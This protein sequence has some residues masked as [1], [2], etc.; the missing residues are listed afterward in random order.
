MKRSL[1]IDPTIV[2][3]IPEFIRAYYNV[4]D[5]HTGL[6]S[7]FL[8]RK[9]FSVSDL[10]TSVTMCTP[11][12]SVIFNK[13]R[14]TPPEESIANG[15][16]I[17]EIEQRFK[18][19]SSVD[20]L[21]VALV[22]PGFVLKSLVADK[23][24]KTLNSH[25]YALLNSRPFIQMIPSDASA[26]SRITLCGTFTSAQKAATL[27]RKNWN[28][29]LC[30]DF[31]DTYGSQNVFLRDHPNYIQPA[32]NF[33]PQSIFV[34]RTDSSSNPVSERIVNMMSFGSTSYNSGASADEMDAATD[35]YDSTRNYYV[36]EQGREPSP[37]V[38]EDFAAFHSANYSKSRDLSDAPFMF[39]HLLPGGC[40]G[41]NEPNRPIKMSHHRW[42]C[43]ML[44]VHHRG[45]QMDR[46]FPAWGQT[47]ES[48]QNSY[49][50]HFLTMRLQPYIL[51]NSI[52]AKDSLRECLNYARVVENCCKHGIQKPV[53]PDIVKDLMDIEFGVRNSA[54]A[55]PGSNE[56]VR[57]ARHILLSF[58]WHSGQHFLF[59]T[60]SP[61][62]D[63]TYIISI[64]NGIISQEEAAVFRIPNHLPSGKEGSSFKES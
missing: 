37:I 39:V 5:I 24:K 26:S 10:S 3:D 44:N 62:T 7:M 14:T 15:N 28:A 4:S 18:S 33:A 50:A 31:V 25:F 47:S 23:E 49:G 35:L 64:Q 6:G 40:G 27:S 46:F 16:W 41:P 57:N 21:S 30:R 34:D 56:S 32:E 13:K 8:Q 29:P 1:T 60:I 63:G 38:S 22:V 42:F 20:K 61:A 43:H 54:A 52:V 9:R 17:G 55:Y 19:M 53:A 45:P 36:Y 12:K 58:G 51:H 11:Y 2:E 59:T 48:R